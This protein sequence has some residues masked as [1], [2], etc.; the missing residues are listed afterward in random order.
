M[1][2]KREEEPEESLKYKEKLYLNRKG[3][4][5]NF[6]SITREKRNNMKLAGVPVGAGTSLVGSPPVAHYTPNFEMTL[7]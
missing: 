6:K 7:K 5:S 1:E 3:H 4:Q 2:E